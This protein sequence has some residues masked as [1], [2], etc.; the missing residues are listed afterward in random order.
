M[1][2]KALVFFVLSFTASVKASP[3]WHSGLK[4]NASLQT[5]PQLPAAVRNTQYS[6]LVNQVSGTMLL[7]SSSNTAGFVGTITLDDELTISSASLGSVTLESGAYTMDTWLAPI[8]SNGV[9][10]VEFH[11]PTVNAQSHNLNFYAIINSQNY[12]WNG[13]FLDYP[14]NA[15][16]YPWHATKS[17]VGSL[18]L[19]PTVWSSIKAG[20]AGTFNLP[21]GASTEDTSDL[22]QQQGANTA[23]STFYGII[24]KHGANYV[25]MV[26]SNGEN[27][28]GL[29]RQ[30]GTVV[31]GAYSSPAITDPNNVV[32]PWGATAAIS[33][34]LPGAPFPWTQT[35][36][37]LA[38]GYGGTFTIYY[39]TNNTLQVTLQWATQPITS[40]TVNLSSV[41]QM[42]NVNGFYKYGAWYLDWY[43]TNGQQTFYMMFDSDGKGF[44][45][46]FKM[47]CYC[48]F[49]GI[50]FPLEGTI[51]P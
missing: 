41:E 51:Q 43:R 6:I 50:L 11:L 14:N 33:A 32:S 47:D 7:T 25:N 45:G 22:T 13:I 34:P 15:P 36:I 16:M 20:R 8:V 1:M 24:Q 44:R 49:S 5:A 42:T 35:F 3:P 9:Y 17:A 30:D 28:W 48:G 23:S 46:H 2:I 29:L 19:P 4:R 37:G 38:W 39:D 40:G 21:T 26:R 18:S 31:Y 27:E 12:D 10:F